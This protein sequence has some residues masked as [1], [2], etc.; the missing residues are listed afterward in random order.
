MD[1]ILLMLYCDNQRLVEYY[2]FS[3]TGR[4]KHCLMLSVVGIF[5]EEFTG[6]LCPFLHSAVG[7]MPVPH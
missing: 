2:F 4:A 7:F 5:C 6:K 1:E 3:E